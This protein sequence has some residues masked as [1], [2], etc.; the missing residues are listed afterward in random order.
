MQIQSIF[1]VSDHQNFLG[2]EIFLYIFSIIRNHKF[3][4]KSSVNCDSGQWWTYFVLQDKALNLSVI[5]TLGQDT[6][7]TIKGLEIEQIQF[8][9]RETFHDEQNLVISQYVVQLSVTLA[10]DAAWFPQATGLTGA[11]ELCR[12]PEGCPNNTSRAIICY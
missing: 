6:S 8:F 7:A 11:S 4:V 1:K 3:A 2:L 9:K 10:S 12:K 5:I